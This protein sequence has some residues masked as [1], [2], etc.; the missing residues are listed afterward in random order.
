MRAPARRIVLFSP[1]GTMPLPER[2]PL[3]KFG[4]SSLPPVPPALPR[5]MWYLHC[6]NRQALER[7]YTSWEGLKAVELHEM[8]IHRDGPRLQFR[9]ELPRFPDWPP[10]R[11]RRGENAVQV[12]VSFW[13]VTG[14]GID[15]WTNR[16]EGLLTVTGEGEERRLAF[17]SSAMTLEAGFTV[18][19]IDR[20]TAYIDEERTTG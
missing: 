19:R 6:E 18:A 4:A 8:V 1:A 2:R 9:I 20:F 3:P 11:W 17:R 16:N 5:S 15:G 14:L 7:L 10:P 12:E 13:G